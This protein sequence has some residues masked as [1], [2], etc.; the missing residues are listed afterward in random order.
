MID[1]YGE[2]LGEPEFWKLASEILWVHSRLKRGHVFFLSRAQPSSEETLDTYHCI[3][4]WNWSKRFARVHKVIKSGVVTYYPAEIAGLQLEEHGLIRRE[5]FGVVSFRPPSLAIDLALLG[6]SDLLIH[7]EERPSANPAGSNAPGGDTFEKVLRTMRQLRTA[8]TPYV[9]GKMVKDQG[10]EQLIQELSTA[11]CLEHLNGKY[12]IFGPVSSRLVDTAEK[13]ARTHLDAASALTEVINQDAIFDTFDFLIEAEFHFRA[14]GELRTSLSKFVIIAELLLASRSSGYVERSIEDYYR[15][16]LD[17][18]GAILD[19]Q[20]FWE[21]RRFLKVL[22]ESRTMRRKTSQET[23]FSGWIFTRED[24]A[25]EPTPG[26]LH[27][28]LMEMAAAKFGPAFAL[29]LKADEARSDRDLT[30]QQ[31]QS[32]ARAFLVNAFRI[33]KRAQKYSDLAAVSYDLAILDCEIG[34]ALLISGSYQSARF[35]QKRSIV[36]TQIALKNAGQDFSEA[37]KAKALDNCAA[38]LLALGQ[39]KQADDILR[40][41]VQDMP[42]RGHEDKGVLYANLFRTSLAIEEYEKAEGFYFSS[43]LNYTYAHWRARVVKNGVDVFIRSVFHPSQRLP[44][45]RTIYKLIVNSLEFETDPV[46]YQEVL[47]KV[48]QVIDVWIVHSTKLG[49]CG[50]AI[51][52]LRDFLKLVRPGEEKEWSYLILRYS[53][54][55]IRG[56]PGEKTLSTLIPLLSK[57]GPWGRSYKQFAEW[58]DN[59]GVLEELQGLEGYWWWKEKMWDAF[60]W[61]G[62]MLSDD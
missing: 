42:I 20:S 26:N 61:A 60:E 25:G 6:L 58:V 32:T 18:I 21:I 11:G 7:V 40:K 41:I 14:A 29:V 51:R 43:N 1:G 27:G 12:R 59:G 15:R 22:L 10:V 36:W 30:E 9:I 17:V 5:S 23:R 52:S 24:R 47:D 45:S 57:R 31:S 44:P 46:S 39:V 37:S 38:A 33:L 56:F 49:H 50:D 8:Q 3:N 62:N 13:E 4:C 2:V 54:L 35:R 19:S 34:N 16:G 28:A 55:I 48:L 53:G